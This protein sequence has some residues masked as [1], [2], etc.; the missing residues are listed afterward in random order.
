MSKKLKIVCLGGGPSSLYF[1]I[2]M[3]KANPEHDIT[4]IERGENAL[5]NSSPIGVA[6]IRPSMARR[7]TRKAMGF[8]GCPG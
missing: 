6:S 3:K 4:V 2:L 5:S 8:V 7:S 1:S